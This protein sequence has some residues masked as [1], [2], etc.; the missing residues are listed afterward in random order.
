[1]RNVN[2]NFYTSTKNG[3]F[4]ERCGVSNHYF[5]RNN[6]RYWGIDFSTF[7]KLVDNCITYNPSVD[8]LPT[9]ISK[10]C[11]RSVKNKHIYYGVEHCFKLI[12]SEDMV[13]VLNKS[14]W[15]TNRS[16]TYKPKPYWWNDW[17]VVSMWKCS[18]EGVLTSQPIQPKEF[19]KVGGKRFYL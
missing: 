6:E 3:G 7:V 16:G 8:E 10:D 13:V 15:V 17:V 11:I 1:M 2:E 18:G 14:E 19:I 4:I 5:D 12:P 9:N